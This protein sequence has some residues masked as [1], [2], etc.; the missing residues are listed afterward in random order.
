MLHTNPSSSI[1]RRR[2]EH[3]RQQSLEVPIL[4]SPLPTNSKRTKSSR[5][6]HQRGRSLDQDLGAMDS[7]AGFRP[8]LPQD[9]QLYHGLP[10][11]LP[12]ART[13]PDTNLAYL[14]DQQHIIKQ[15]TQSHSLAQPGF[16]P[17]PLQAQPQNFQSHLHQQLHGSMDP[18]GG[19]QTHEQAAAMQSLQS[20]LMWYEQNFGSN[21]SNPPINHPPHPNHNLIPHPTMQNGPFVQIS[22]PP[23]TDMNSVI[24]LP[25]QPLQ[26]V[27]MTPVS[28]GHSRT[29]PNTPQHHSQAWPSPPPTQRKTTRSN[30]HQLDVA[31]M[32]HGQD[33]GQFVNQGQMFQNN[34]F[35]YASEQE[36]AASTYSS[37]VADPSSPVH[38]QSTPMPTLFEEVS[39]PYCGQGDI[40]LQAAAGADQDFNSPHFMMGDGSACAEQAALDAAGIDAT[41]IDT[42]ISEEQINSWLVHPV[43]KGEAYTCKWEGCNTTINRKENARSH[44]QNHLDDRRFRCNPC[45][46]RFN[47][48]HDTKRHHLTHTNERPAVCPCGKTFARADALTRHRQ[49]DM[50]EGVLPG[51]EKLEEEK[52]KRGRPKKDRS[53]STGPSHRSE[54]PEMDS[55]ARK[56]ALAR[57][58]DQVYGNGSAAS[59]SSGASVRSM[60][61]TPPQ[62]SDELAVGAFLDLNS[63]NAQFTNAVAA[64]LDTPPTS[65]PSATKNIR[66]D[67]KVYIDLSIPEERVVSPSKLSTRSS[68]PATTG[69]DAATFHDYSSPA[70]NNNNSGFAGESSPIGP[71]H[72]IFSDAVNF[73]V[74]NSHP[75]VHHDAFSP[76]GESC[77]GSSVYNSD[78]DTVQVSS[79]KNNSTVNAIPSTIYEEGFHRTSLGMDDFMNDLM[80]GSGDSYHD[81]VRDM[82]DSWVAMN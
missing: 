74:L 41:Y 56:A 9:Q 13:H 28:R 8:L 50:C 65:P 22:S 76:P 33:L 62:E 16:Q 44:V 78:W 82:L 75:E 24:Y 3:R 46:K 58:M 29:V 51:F 30:S 18:S 39:N 54:R 69:V 34:S 25:Q 60:P 53:E 49:R 67:S 27:P 5:S 20:H 2:L 52:P 10:S 48:L 35:T 43:G 37:S 26:A 72:D 66:S 12:L 38:Q 31:P 42:G 6:G 47:R 45:G 32:P 77:S 81:D 63:S 40:L 68:P 23:P 79:V 73:D 7:S 70:Y 1:Q 55:R 14:P 21:P 71:E 36:Y 64:W 11:G 15:E 80:G 59:S 61:D 17:A 4:A 19:G 57:R